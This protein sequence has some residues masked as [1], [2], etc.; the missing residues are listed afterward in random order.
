MSARVLSRSGHDM[1]REIQLMARRRI[2]GLVV[3]SSL[4]S[5]LRF[6]RSAVLH[7]R[8][9]SRPFRRLAPELRQQLGS[10][11]WGCAV[12]GPR[13]DFSSCVPLAVDEGRFAAAIWPFLV[14]PG[15]VWCKPGIVRAL[16]C[17]CLCSSLFACAIAAVGA[18]APSECFNQLLPRG[19]VVSPRARLLTEL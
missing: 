14:V 6:P 5:A 12:G 18:L 7:V 9:V 16:M 1:P 4:R 3:A 13:R 15:S 17:T 10:G 11:S 2:H 8:Y 19:L